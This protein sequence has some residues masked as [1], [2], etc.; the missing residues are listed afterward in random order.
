MARTTRRP[1]AVAVAVI[2]PGPVIRPVNVVRSLLPPWS[3]SVPTLVLIGPEKFGMRFRGSSTLP[4]IAPETL[5]W[6]AFAS[7]VLVA[8]AAMRAGL[9][10]FGVLPSPRV[11]VPVPRALPL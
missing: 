2:D 7:V 11:T 1:A 5:L 9:A 6:M 8:A 3:V 10:P 4:T